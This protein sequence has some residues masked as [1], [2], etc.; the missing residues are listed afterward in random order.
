MKTID[1]ITDSYSIY[2]NI[3]IYNKHYDEWPT[4]FIKII[5][6]N[7]VTYRK[8]IIIRIIT[9]GSPVFSKM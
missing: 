3:K 8:E 4:S 2:F 7:S 9:E 6:S 5:K 1:L